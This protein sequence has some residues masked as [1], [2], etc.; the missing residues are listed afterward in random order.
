MG[1]GPAGDFKWGSGLTVGRRTLLEWLLVVSITGA[2]VIW[3]VLGGGAERANNLFYDAMIRLDGRPA[4]ERIVIVA[5]DDRSL[6]ELG[7]WP[8]DR[9]VHAEMVGRLSAARPRAVAYDVLFTESAPGDDQLAAALAKS[10]LVSLPELIDGEGENGSPWRSRPPVA[11]LTGSATALGHVNLTIDADGVIRRAPLFMRSGDRIWPHLML[12]LAAREGRAPPRPRGGA[13]DE[14]VAIDAEMIAY[15]GT[16]GRYRTISFVDLLRGETP[17]AFLEGRLVLVGVTAAGLGDRYATPAAPHGELS[18]GVEIQAALLQTLLEGGGPRPVPGGLIAA[19]SLAP[20]LALAAGFL[21]F[22]PLTNMLAGAGL[23]LAILA[24]SY[25]AFQIFRLW[26]PPAAAITGL[27]IAYPLWSWRRLAVASAYLQSELR[28]FERDERLPSTEIFKPS[29]PHSSGDVLA[30]Q[31]EAFQAS[32]KQ[33]RNLD[34]FITETLRGLPDATVVAG[35]DGK[36]IIAND[37]A[38]AVFGPDVDGAANLD[39]LLTK[40]GEPAWRR[41]LTRNGDSPTDIVTSNGQVLHPAAA[42]IRDADGVL[43]GWIIRFTDLTRRRAE[44]RERERTMQLL[45]HDMRAPQV[46]ILTLLDNPTIS[47]SP[48]TRRRIAAYARHT[49]SL[50]D[51]YVQL[52]RAETQP[53]QAVIFDLAQVLVES[54]DALWPQASSKGATI[55]VSTAEERWVRGDPSML[56]RAIVNLLDNGLKFG[57]PGGLIDC[58]LRPAAAG[59]GPQWELWI[60]DEGPGLSEDA[61]ARL[62]E[63]FAH[64][65]G[66][67]DGAGLGLAFV[68]TVAQRHGGQ[69]IYR[70]TERGAGFSLTIP[71]ADISIP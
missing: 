15:P 24:G 12:R 4:D 17:P 28:A 6:A 60:E 49:L 62:F 33:L 1:L 43:M 40:L 3:M 68:R 14:L 2:I 52:A 13:R 29:E 64:G 58:V 69:I 65:G 30:R 5:I 59:G 21:F 35:Q 51:G 47:A 63:P 36:V 16:P 37:L 10:G 55:R 11:R 71:Q 39:D 50:A 56:R 7:Q 38:R 46:S 27:L 53:Y 34:R 19:L 22:R 70:P 61:A 48:D 25:V 20:L 44:E 54:A 57:P 45:S 42:E 26:T 32:L 8:W 18:P 66:E 23:V 41:L 67:V 31:V 9:D